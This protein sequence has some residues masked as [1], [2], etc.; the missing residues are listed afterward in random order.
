MT[1][2]EIVE[3]AKVLAAGFE[4]MGLTPPVQAEGREW[5]FMGIQ[6][7]NRKEWYLTHLANMHNRGTSVAFYDTLGPEAA[8]YICH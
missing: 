7:K 8:R 5:R 6:S 3:T 4:A 2:R 1:V